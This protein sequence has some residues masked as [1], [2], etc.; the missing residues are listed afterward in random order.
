[1]KRNQ[2]FVALVLGIGSTLALLWLLVG[3]PVAVQADPD[4]RFVATDGDDFNDCSS[5]EQR[6]RTVQRAIDVADAFDEIWVATGTYTD[7][8]G[9][10][11]DIDKTVILLGGWDDGFT[12]RAPGIYPTVLDAERNDRVIYISGAISPT[13]DGFTITGGDATSAIHFAYQGGGIYSR[14]ANPIITNSV[15]T[16]N[17][18]S[19]NTNIGRGGGL[20][21]YNSSTS[22]IV[23]GNHILSNT[24]S[25]RDMGVGGGLYLDHS[26]ARV[27]DNVVQG[28]LASAADLGDGAGLYLS[29]SPALVRGNIISDNVAC[30]VGGQG[31]GVV[32]YYSQATLDGNHIINNLSPGGGGGLF[33]E[34]STPFTLTNNVI[35]QNQANN[36]GRGGGIKVWG[37]SGGPASGMLVHNTIA[38][39]DLGSDGE[40]IFATGTTTLTLSN[41]VIVSH[42]YGIYATGAVV[43]ATH[44]LF[45][46]NTSGDTGGTGSITNTYVFA[47]D[48]SFVNPAGWDYDLRL[49]S[50]AVDAGL[51]V[52]W[53]HS[54]IR[55]NRRHFGPAPDL[56]AYEVAAALSIYKT[57]PAMVDPGEL[58]TYTLSVTN[59]GTFTASTI[60]ITDVLPSGAHYV[61]GGTLMPE[62]VV[63]WTVGS[64]ARGGAHVQVQFIVT[65]TETI[66]NNA[67]G[68][69]CAEG[70]SAQG[71]K[72][73]VTI[74]GDPELA[75]GKAGPAM[76]D[77]GAPITYTLTVT[78]N[79]PAPATGLVITDVLPAG[80]GYVSGGTLM[81]GNVVS[82]TIANLAGDGAHAQVQFIVAAT[83]RI[84][85]AVYGVTC[86][87]GVSAVGGEPVV[88]AITFVGPD[89]FFVTTGGSGTA[90]T[91]AVPCALQTALDQATDGYTIYV[92]QGT[93]TGAGG[94]V[95]TATQSIAL[96][97]GWDGAPTGPVNRDPDAYPTILDGEGERRVIYISGPITP[98]L[99]GL[100]ITGGNATSA[101]IYAGRGGGIY[102]EYASPIIQ[103]NV[104]T[105]NTASISPTVGRGGGIYL[106]DASAS[107]LISSNQVLSNTVYGVPAADNGGGGLYLYYSDVAV[108][109][110]LIQG[111]ATDRPG[112]GILVYYGG[113]RIL[114]NE[115]WDNESGGSGGGICLSRVTSG[116][117][118]GNQV[119]SNTATGLSSMGGGLMLSECGLTVRG[120]LIRGN[121][122][123]RWAGGVYLGYSDLLFVDNE[124]RG[125]VSG[126][127]AGGLHLEWSPSVIQGNLIVENEASGAGGGISVYA[128][129]P[130]ITANRISSNTA[131]SA[132]GLSLSSLSYFTVTNNVIVH[133]DNGGIKFW[134]DNRHSLVAHNTVVY[135]GGDGG[136][137]LAYEHITPTIVN[138]V[139]VS[140]SYGIR[141]HTDASGTL[142]YND[143]WGNTS[144]DYD[145]PGAL[146]PGAH[147]I[148]A[149]PR[150]VDA[151][152]NDYHLR[153]DSHCINAGL[154]VGVL[155]DM[156]GELRPNGLGPDIGADEYYFFCTTALTGAGIDG[157]SSGYTDTLYVFAAVVTPADATLPITYTWSPEPD[158]GQSSATASYTW[159]TSGTQVITLT[160]ENCGGSDTVTHTIT[161]ASPP[162]GCPRPLTGVSVSGPGSGYTSTLYTFTAVVAP[163]DATL[164]ITYTWSPEPDAGQSSATA[165]Y[166]WTTS[167]TQVITLTAENCGGNDTVTHTITIASPP[168]G[169]LRPLTGVSLSGPTGGYIDTLYTFTASAAPPDATPPITYTWQAMEQSQVVTSTD[170][171]SHTVPFTWASSGE[172]IIT[173]TVQNC[174]DSDVAHHTITIEAEGQFDIYLPL[175]LKNY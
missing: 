4:T 132:A 164:P 59:S 28:N 49:S 113:P 157:P 88:T 19:T 51:A 54:D 167:G 62:D 96:Y 53:L 89:V 22:A 134:E 123:S 110:N 44:T 16:G 41:N 105:N 7:P 141:A 104:I 87:E 24:A 66:I 27:S 38:Q 3:Q 20:Y 163:A 138:N 1:M 173:V 97:G 30:A 47:K 60:V 166:T 74:I 116:I 36:M 73:V 64:L 151:V 124:V 85:N 128:E 43:S 144:Q 135:N 72:D 95:V 143:V 99:D 108:Q 94:A 2:W 35:A 17:V 155:T 10:V 56:G 52:P 131:D 63:S 45:Y 118:S 168:P 148:Q 153:F 130:T 80:A 31:G 11:A 57:G 127:S 158:A 165:S 6:C 146:E 81:P 29:S 92:A 61:S 82:W 125:N 26:A 77:A 111:N 142:D 37:W 136:I 71:T 106:Y 161:I 160:A 42:T 86:A 98:T 34:I 55:G 39:N 122:S 172:K 69:T 115:I 76:A 79:G 117:I 133:N 8:A 67:Y 84:T 149:D 107:A 9:M 48:P 162:P 58:I 40:G 147:S 65:A 93:Y 152:E 140:N 12:T 18:A 114:D 126:N 13:V 174:G 154:D 83:E 78:N 25:I 159:T 70:V 169:C 5:I 75:I 121:V 129:G 175:V 103:N 14:D 101:T 150:F 21:L 139:I 33:V 90:C 15:I 137:Y 171:T 100:T 23:S 120:N 109:G 145:L 102:S 91:Q 46:G 112:G 68:V 50:P 119:L 170:A 32:L 156:D